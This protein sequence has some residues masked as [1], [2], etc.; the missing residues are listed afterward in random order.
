[1]KDSIR[2]ISISRRNISRRSF[3]CV[4][5]AGLVAIAEKFAHS[6]DKTQAK[7]WIDAHVHVWTPDTAKYPI[8]SNFQMIDMQPPSFTADEL[9]AHC[10]PV[11]VNRVVL[12]QMSFYEYD[13]RYMLDVMAAHPNTFSGVA[14][15]DYRADDLVFKM[16]E[17]AKQGMRGFRLHSQGDAKD[18]VDHKGMAKL[19]KTASDEGLAVC[20]LINPGDI[21]Y[22]DQLC[23]RYPTTTVVVDHFARI[24]VS[25]QIETNSLKELCRMS[26][27]P[28]VYVKTSAFYALGKKKPPYD[29]LGKMIQQVVEAFGPQRLM[30]ASDC[31]YQVQGEHSYAASIELI[32]DRLDFL[33]VSDKQWML[34]DTAAKVF[35]HS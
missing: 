15:I 28:N 34:R 19:W 27:F 35:F 26:R 12:I 21:P 31:P 33:S 11:G 6:D 1:M 9:F 13:H 2:P 16:K 10:R 30:W 3:A 22:V 7:D 29:D 17:L 24:G 20:P 5:T 4:S 32:R 23:D 14:L 8:S 25:G 18:W